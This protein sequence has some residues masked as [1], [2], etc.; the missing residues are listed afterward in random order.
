MPNIDGVQTR[1]MAAL[2][3]TLEDSLTNAHGSAPLSQY[4]WPVMKTS[5]M[6]LFPHNGYVSVFQDYH[7]LFTL[8]S[9]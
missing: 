4:P 5:A 1:G 8:H 6:T 3:A 7:S 2:S 9:K